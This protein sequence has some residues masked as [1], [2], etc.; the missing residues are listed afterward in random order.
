[1]N[2]VDLLLVSLVDVVSGEDSRDGNFGLASVHFVN[3]GERYDG[4]HRVDYG[5][6]QRGEQEL[7]NVMRRATEILRR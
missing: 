6:N 4:Q 7:K 3:R 1:L 5:D 2:V